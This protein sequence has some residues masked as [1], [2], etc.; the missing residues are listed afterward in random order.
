ML[1]RSR[2][3][4]TRA[5]PVE[6]VNVQPVH[7]PAFEGLMQKG[8]DED[9]IKEHAKV[10]AEELKTMVIGEN[11]DHQVPLEA[12]NALI[13]ALVEVLPVI[14]YCKYD[15]WAELPD[16]LVAQDVLKKARKERKKLRKEQIQLDGERLEIQEA[17]ELLKRDNNKAALIEHIE[18]LEWKI[19]VDAKRFNEAYEAFQ[20]FRT[21]FRELMP[22]I[23][24]FP[25]CHQLFVQNMMENHNDVLNWLTSGG[26]RLSFES[27]G[28]PKPAS[29]T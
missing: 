25:D 17:R 9:S 24:K 28:T 15:V 26:M 6:T 20:R 22:V 13:E 14:L 1:F 4:Q 27:E 10:F 21:L 3:V 8:E 7:T 2:R 12:Y 29:R 23:R 18:K 5:P 19:K 16:L 11:P